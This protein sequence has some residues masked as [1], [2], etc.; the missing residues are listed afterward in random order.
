MESAEKLMASVNETW[1][2]KLRKTQ[3]IQVERERALE[4]LGISVEKGNVGVHTPKKVRAQL[5]E[6]EEGGG[7]AELT[8][9]SRTQLPHLVNLNEDPLM[10]ECLVYQL[11]HG[12]TTVG[13]SES[14]HEGDGPAIRL[15]GSNILVRSGEWTAAAVLIPPSPQPQHCQFDFTPDGTVLILN[16]GGGMTMVNGKRVA[17][18]EP[19]RL[20]SGYRVILVR[21]RGA[22]C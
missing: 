21:R 14:E 9:T 12:I 5:D 11:R 19:R 16:S 13:N 22:M 10:S 17:P 18:D 7:V 8:H 20:R 4:E 2:D 1:E 6:E 15:S 3:E